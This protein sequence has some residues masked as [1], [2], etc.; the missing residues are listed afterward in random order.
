MSAR[1]LVADGDAERGQRIADACSSQGLT[2]SVT[3]HGAAALENALAE[4]PDALVCQLELPLIDGPR[5]VAILRANPR[6]RKVSVLFVGDRA[7]DAENGAVAGQVIPAP[8]DPDLVVSCLQ[9]TLAGRTSEA[10]GGGAENNVEGQLG[11]LPLADVL[12]LFNV[13]RKSGTVDVVCGLGPGRC[14]TG[15]IV[16]REGDVVSASVE[17]VQ[18]EKALFRLL[19]WD[20]G[21]FSF[22][23]EI[24]ECEPNVRTPTRALLREGMRQI[25]EWE[26]LAVELPPMSAQVTLRVARAGLPSV[27]HPLTQEVLMVLDLYSK[28]EEVVDHCSFPDYQ[29]LRTLHTLHRRG[30]VDLLNEPEE[31]EGERGVRL[32]P[33]ARAARLREWLGVDR[34]GQ[35][36]AREAKLVIV[37]SDTASLRELGRILERIPGTELE[38]GLAKGTTTADDLVTLGRIGV[39]PEVGIRLINAPSSPRFAPIWPIVAHGALAVV[40]AIPG[41]GGATL[42]PLRRAAHALQTL[43]R[44][45][46]FPLVL[47]EKGQDARES[48]LREALAFVK[49][50]PLILLPLENADQAA[51]ALRELFGRILS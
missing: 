41:S 19:T 47:L 20:R 8:A 44:T 3:T 13:S 46:I 31:V 40:L 27:I 34:P 1:V 39:D 42:E 28:V 4:V 33:P 15:R 21:T 2:C 22:R 6:T 32:F 5:L 17:R 30:M 37:T 18:G 16:L 45:R 48:E 10:S 35:L 36:A 51:T 7:S 24:P 14:Q 29:V 43:P 23:P 11:Q 38:E 26:R 50:E 25:R 49:S 12:Q 9:A